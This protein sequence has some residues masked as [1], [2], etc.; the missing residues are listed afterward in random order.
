M[1]TFLNL[2][3]IYYLIP[4]V[5]AIDNKFGLLFS[6]LIGRKNYK[7]KTKGHVINFKSS[8]FMVMLDFIAVLMYSVSHKITPDNKI[9]I[10]I[11]FI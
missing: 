11:I 9:H 1:S 7:V 6:I 3:L 5:S 10:N 2:G 4:Y 8:Q